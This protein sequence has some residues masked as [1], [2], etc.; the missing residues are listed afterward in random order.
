MSIKGFADDAGVWRRNSTPASS[1]A[2]RQERGDARDVTAVRVN[3]EAELVDDLGLLADPR[4]A[5]DEHGAPR[6]RRD[7]VGRDDVEDRAAQ[8]RGRAGR[9]GPGA[10]G[11][12]EDRLTADVGLRRG[13]LRDPAGDR[14]RGDLVVQRE[15]ATVVLLDRVAALGLD[16]AGVGAVR[17]LELGDAHLVEP[18][19]TGARAAL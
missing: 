5:T 2:L 4:G 13:G 14:E 18:V 9:E 10:L 7:L 1:F 19:R 6:R 15:G 3:G 16:D 8:V 11:V 17:D 12:G